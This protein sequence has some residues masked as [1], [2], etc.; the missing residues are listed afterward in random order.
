[1]CLRLLPLVFYELSRRIL[2]DSA[3]LHARSSAD[4]LEVATLLNLSAKYSCTRLH[5]SALHLLSR[6]FPSSL[7]RWD[8]RKY[9][10]HFERHVFEVADA[11]REARAWTLLPTALLHCCLR[12]AANAMIGFTP[13][14]SAECYALSEENAK[15]VDQ[16]QQYLASE[17]HKDVFPDFYSPDALPELCY[18]PHHCVRAKAKLSKWM[19]ASSF[20]WCYRAPTFDGWLKTWGFCQHCQRT[21]GQQYR[22]G[23]VEVWNSLP[24]VFGLGTWEALADKQREEEQARVAESDTASVSSSET[25]AESVTELAVKADLS[26]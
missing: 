11:A 25:R 6:Q 24:R 17:I 10:V 22:D 20:C 12:Q 1:M 2:F 21:Y 3:R 5:A 26:L 13:A 4:V 14:Q 15:A 8:K 9:N 16:S 7:E 18:T 19:A 23:R